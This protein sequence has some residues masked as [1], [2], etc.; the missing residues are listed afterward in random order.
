VRKIAGGFL[1]TPN[2]PS[3]SNYLLGVRHSAKIGTPVSRKEFLQ[4]ADPSAQCGGAR[5]KL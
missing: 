3:G 1:T 2:A 5:Q 4:L